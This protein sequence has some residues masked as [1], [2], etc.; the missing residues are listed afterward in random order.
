MR[1][2]T[3]R[4]EFAARGDQPP[5]TGWYYDTIN[6]AFKEHRPEVT[7]DPGMVQF[8]LAGIQ[9]ALGDLTDE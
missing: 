5:V 7:W 6:H 8:F 2:R 9:Y 3:I 4:F 1:P